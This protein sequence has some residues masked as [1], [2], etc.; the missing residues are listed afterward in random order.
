MCLWLAMAAVLLWRR[1]T[2][3]LR[4][5]LL[6]LPL[7]RTRRQTVTTLLSLLWRSMPPQPR[8][9]LRRQVRATVTRSCWDQC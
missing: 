3:A 4:T 8:Q 5:P 1:V 2:T 9:M 6:R 7:L